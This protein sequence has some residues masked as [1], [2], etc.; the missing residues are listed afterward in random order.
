VETETKFY[1]FDALLPAK[2]G[3]WKKETRQSSEA[4]F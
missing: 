4:S 2:T 3:S 1:N